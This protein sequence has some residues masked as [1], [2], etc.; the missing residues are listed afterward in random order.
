MRT[1]HHDGGGISTVLRSTL[2]SNAEFIN[3]IAVTIAFA[4]GILCPFHR[5][6]QWVLIARPS[7][8]AGIVRLCSNGKGPGAYGAD[9]LATVHGAPCWWSFA[10]ST[11]CADRL[12]AFEGSA[13]V[14]SSRWSDSCSAVEALR[15]G[16]ASSA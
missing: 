12:R 10:C 13:R 11:G 15:G 5:D 7:A 6:E 9:V 14:Y 4:R 3:C 2:T 1:F 16:K 8:G